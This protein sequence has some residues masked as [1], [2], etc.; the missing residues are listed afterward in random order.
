LFLPWAQIVAF[1]RA[2][3][4]GDGFYRPDNTFEEIVVSF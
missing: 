4:G 2:M 1:V 3:I